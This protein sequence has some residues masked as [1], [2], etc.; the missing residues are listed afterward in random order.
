M[1]PRSLSSVFR[2]CA[3]HSYTV[4]SRGYCQKTSMLPTRLRA[5]CRQLEISRML[6]KDPFGNHIAMLWCLISI[7]HKISHL[8]TVISFGL[9]DC[10][11]ARHGSLRR[12][13][14]LKDVWV[15]TSLVWRNL[16]C[17]T[18]Q[19]WRRD[20]S[21]ASLLSDYTAAILA[22]QRAQNRVTTASV[23]QWLCEEPTI[24]S[25][26]SSRLSSVCKRPATCVNGFKWVRRKLFHK[27]LC[28]ESACRN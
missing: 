15:W 5:M 1:R 8:T 28:H 16:D 21:G 23:T 7:A 27:R 12:R 4:S 25:T 11:A 10:A 24:R 3:S 22:V 2:H 9:L 20:W 18:A 13:F 19:F 26:A 6:S 14:V 17:Y